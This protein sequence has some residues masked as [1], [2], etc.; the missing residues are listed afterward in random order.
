MK[1]FNL[2]LFLLF[3]I[4]ITS[5]EKQEIDKNKFEVNIDMRI[6]SINGKTSLEDNEKFNQPQECNIILF[7]TIGEIKR[8]RVINTCEM[9]KNDGCSCKSKIK[10]D[11]DWIYKHKVGDIIH[12]DYLLK[13]KFFEM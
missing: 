1:K 10:I 9:A 3:S 12:F 6:V 8:Y 4:I 5:C 11:N 7:E 2:L 13:S